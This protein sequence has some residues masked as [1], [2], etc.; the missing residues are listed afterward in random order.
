MIC[1][2]SRL[3][4]VSQ[5]LPTT[6]PG[7]LG[8][9]GVHRND[10]EAAAGVFERRGEVVNVVGEIGDAQQRR[11]V[12]ILSPLAVRL[13]LDPICVVRI[14]PGSVPV[15]VAA[16]AAFLIWGHQATSPP[17]VPLIGRSSAAR[18]S[19]SMRMARGPTR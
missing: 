6:P 12:V 1:S 19:V 16:G 14:G 4:L 15:V 5:F 17:A 2:G 9:G 11:A 18:S 10:V 8:I 13:C 3:D 7:F